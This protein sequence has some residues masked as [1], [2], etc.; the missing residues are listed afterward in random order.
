MLY[1]VHELSYHKSYCV[2]HVSPF[3]GK[4]TSLVGFLLYKHVVKPRRGPLKPFA[5]AEALSPF[6][7]SGVRLWVRFCTVRV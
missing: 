6:Y 7:Q 5:G 2:N 4:I 3:V 1:Y